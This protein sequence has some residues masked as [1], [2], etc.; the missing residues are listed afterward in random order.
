MLAAYKNT[1]LTTLN[2]SVMQIKYFATNSA[3]GLNLSL[4]GA[5]NWITGRAR[6]DQWQPI[7]ACWQVSLSI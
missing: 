4:I 6:S 5:W 1:T 2:Q 3:L 7:Q